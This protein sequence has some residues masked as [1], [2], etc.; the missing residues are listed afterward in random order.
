MPGA[1][2]DGVVDGHDGGHVLLLGLVA[3]AL[4]GVEEHFLR[5]VDPVS[6]G[7]VVACIALSVGGQG[8]TFG[9]IERFAGGGEGAGDGGDF[10][11]G[12]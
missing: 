3:F 4:H 7:F 2:V 5:G 12:V 11:V 9:G 8:C 10:A 1:L 6:G